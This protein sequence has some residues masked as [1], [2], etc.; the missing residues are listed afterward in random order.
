VPYNL[1]AGA[2]APDRGAGM[3]F[4]DAINSH[5]AWKVHLQNHLLG[6]SHADFDV[7]SAAQDNRC[8]LGH[9]LYDNLALWQDIPLY[10]K[11]IEQHAAFHRCAGEII[12]L[13]AA[14]KTA[15]AERVLH[16]EYAE[17]SHALVHALRELSRVVDGS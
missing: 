9:W 10:W 13:H 3:N 5:V 4:F 8:E 11:L 17:L 15:E 12:H 6:L 14:G 1:R 7:N 16:H 2:H